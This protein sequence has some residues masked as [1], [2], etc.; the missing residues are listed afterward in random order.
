VAA[1]QTLDEHF[2]SSPHLVSFVFDRL[3]G[4]AISVATRSPQTDGEDCIEVLM[5]H[6]T[7]N[8]EGVVEDEV[9]RVVRELKSLDRDGHRSVGVVSPFRAQAEA[10]EASVLS[11]FRADAL[12]RMDLR[13]GTVHAFQ[14]NE[15]DVIVA[16]VGVGPDAAAATWRFVEEPH[17]FAVF[18]TRARRRFIILLSADPPTGGLF[19]DYLAQAD[20]PPGAPDPAEQVA[21]WPQAV[22]DD[23]AD[24]GLEVRTAYPTGRHVVDVCVHAPGTSVAVECAVHRDGP[25][26]HIE[27]HLALVRSGWTVLE[28][29]RSRWEG[30]RGELAVELSRRIAKL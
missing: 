24:T 1:V 30:R 14:G 23:L 20:A 6:G 15:R 9:A 11:E 2:R 27:R 21:W 13:V 10:I 12:E 5:L 22:A 16:S 7:R 26:A 29:H 3:Y 8:A 25:A 28:A 17:L 18:A 19:A 4:H